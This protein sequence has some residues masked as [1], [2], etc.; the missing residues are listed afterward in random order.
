MKKALM[1]SAM[2]IIAGATA[3]NAKKIGK[4]YT[5]G[6]AGGGDYCDGFTGLTLGSG[7]ISGYHSYAACGS[8]YPTVAV[9]A[10]DVKNVY[11]MATTPGL[12]AGIEFVFYTDFKALTWVLYYES[13]SYAIP[14][15][16]LNA[17]P[18]VK[19][20]AGI[21]QHGD[22]AIHAGLKSAGFVRK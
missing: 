1:L 22:S 16:E 6:T 9:G 11:A 7:T 19:G 2:V 4:S 14:F 18:L 13:V 10:V 8:G 3:A 12:D 5:F 15:S 20:Y 21:K 17:G